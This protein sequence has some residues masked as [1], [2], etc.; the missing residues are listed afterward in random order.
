MKGSIAA[1]ALYVAAAPGLLADDSKDGNKGDYWLD[2]R[3][4]VE[5][6]EDTSPAQDA[7]ALTLRSIL[8]YETKN[9]SGFTFLVEGENIL[10]L[11]EDYNSTVNGLTQFSV[12]ADPEDT[13]INRLQLSYTNIPGTKLILGRQRIVFD[14][15]RFIG[16]VIWRQNEQTFD[17]FRIVNTSLPDTTINFAYLEKV[18]RIFGTDSPNGTTNM[19]SPLFNVNYRG[20]ENHQVSGYAYL[21]EFDDQP[22]ASHMTLGARLTGDN[23]LGELP[24]KY[25]LELASQSDYADGL[26]TND[27]NYLA[28]SINTRVRRVGFG[29]GYEKLGGDGVYAFQTPLATA[30]AFNGWADRFLTTPVNGLIDTYASVSGQVAGVKLKAIY[31]QFDSDAGGLDYGSE[32][33][34]LATKKFSDQISVGLKYADYFADDFSVDGSRLAIWGQFKY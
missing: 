23:K 27:A 14:N 6:A 11:D 8:G 2:F 7:S 33:D 30:H 19:S 34:F 4:R 32:I 10:A 15:A 13:Q 16:N 24:L 29:V 21:L 17:S 5:T 28:A 3:M 22:G 1:L 12:I 26:A 9:F 25:V 20:F 31:H 18:R